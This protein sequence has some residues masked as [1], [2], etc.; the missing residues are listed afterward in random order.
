[1]YLTT[2]SAL[3]SDHLPILIDTQ[4]RSSFLSQPDRRDLRMTD[5]SKFQAC[6]EAGLPSNLDLPNEVAIDACIK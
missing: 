6:L 5:W 2:C 1:M 4:F 3:S